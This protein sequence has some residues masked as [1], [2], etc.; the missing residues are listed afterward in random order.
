M[1]VTQ[2]AISAMLV[3]TV[4]LPG[5]GLAGARWLDALVGGVVAIV[6]TALLATDPRKAVKQAADSVLE[7]LSKVLDD[8]AAA[9]EHRDAAS[10]I[11]SLQR[12]RALE[13]REARWEDAVEAGREV[14]RTVPAQRRARD[15]MAVYEQAIAAIDL[16][17]RNV[18]VLARGALRVIEVGD[19]VPAELIS[20]VRHLAEAV[21]ELSHDLERLDQ[22]SRA[23]ELALMAAGE[24]TE[25]HERHGSLSVASIAAQVRSTAVDLLRGLGDEPGHARA[26]VRTAP[27]AAAGEEADRV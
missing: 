24:A 8:V 15:T 20:A 14:V 6:V 2:S 1:V 21:R 18:R 7:E 5:S 12:A 9:L 22:P 26:A 19:E 11:A 27:G 17:V 23:R 3:V 4:Q 25:A 10:A 16:A 13:P